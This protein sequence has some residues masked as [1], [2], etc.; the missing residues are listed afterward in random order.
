MNKRIFSIFMVASLLGSATACGSDSAQEASTATETTVEVSETAQEENST[1]DS[2]TESTVEE[3]ASETYEIPEGMYL[4]EITGE[5]ISEEIKDQ[6]PVAVMID[7][8][9]LALPHYGVAEADVVYEMMNSTANNRITRLMCIVKDWGNIEQMG[10]IR[11]TRPTNILLMSEWNAVLC[12]DGGPYYNDQ[13]FIRDWAD[14]FSGTFS[15]V[16]NGKS[17]EYTEYILSGDLE[18]N[19]ED[20]GYS[21]TYNE[22]A[23]ADTTHFEFTDYGTTVDLSENGYQYCADAAIIDI[24]PF[25]HN[26][27]QLIYNEETQTYDYYEYGAVHEDAEDG[28]VLTF[29]N[30]ILQKCTFSQL[31]DEG[32]L[33]YN[34][35]DTNQPG[36]YATKGKITDVVWTKPNETDITR[37][38]DEHGEEIV[39]NTGKTYIALVPDDT[40]DQLAIGAFYYSE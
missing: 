31:D 17:R 4:S 24:K 32:Y 5:P 21:T 28:D 1:D 27:S 19:F 16:A 30:V 13:Y 2:S 29:D 20:S 23:N 37:F 34:C 26:G 15:R 9:S 14:H 11:S 25:A 6:R 12:H 10:S 7:N 36:L 40:W 33:I 22:Y 35:I 38:Y 39:L 8:E 3:V 18:S